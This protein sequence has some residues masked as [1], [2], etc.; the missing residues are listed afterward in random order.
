MRSSYKSADISYADVFSFITVALRPKTIVEFGV[1]DGYTLNIMVNNSEP[2]T[3]IT[4]Y[5]IFEEFNG[6]HAD[7][8]SESLAKFSHI[9]KYGD[10]YTKYTE[11][12]DNSIDL[13]H[14][15]IANNG[16]TYL[17]AVEHYLDKLTDCGIMI[18]E[19]GSLTRDNVEWMNK[20][21]KPKIQPVIDQLNTRL[22]ITLNV[23]GSLPSITMI[24]RNNDFVIRQLLPADFRNGFYSLVNHFTKELDISMLSTLENN[25][26]ELEHT[27]VA[28]YHNKII[29]T[30]RLVHHHK[31]HNNFKQVGHIEDVVVD[32]KYRKSGVG[33]LI[34]KH[35]VSYAYKIDCYK[36]VLCCNPE[37]VGFYEKCGFKQKGT[38]MS[39]YK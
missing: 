32:E 5:D 16:D 37:N 33:K 11:L 34:V 24:T 25:I 13:L 31:A 14:I 23:L 27:I 8:Q 22:D 9:V 19:G 3:S 18:L 36:V 20:Y 35:L 7:R 29:G 21:N 30:G 39:I 4:A 12:T 1:L 38:E 6:N 10:F 15:D 26:S 17:F 28:V 2:D